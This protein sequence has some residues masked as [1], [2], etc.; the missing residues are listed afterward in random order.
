MSV[1]ELRSKIFYWID[2]VQDSLE[3]LSSK[4]EALN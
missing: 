4:F 3:R 2:T 1:T